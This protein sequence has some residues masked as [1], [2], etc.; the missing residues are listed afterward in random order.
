MTRRADKRKTRGAL[1]NPDS[2][3]ATHTSA[4]F[5]DGWGTL[6]A[7]DDPPPA[8]HVHNDPARR[9]ISRNSSPDVGFDYS[10]NPYKGCS[11]GCVYCFARP[12]HE[13]LDHSA[14]LDFETEIYAKHDAAAR[15]EAEL[16]APGYICRPITL[17][18]NTDPYQPDEHALEITRDLLDVA[19]RFNQPVSIVT[20]SG[21]VLRDLDYLTSLA[22]R[23][24]VNVFI[25]LTSLD[26]E[27]KRSLEPRAAAPARRLTTIQT[28]ANAGVPVGV[29]VAPVIPA[30]TDAE[31]E[32]L[33]ARAAE[34]GAECA[35]YVM[36]RLPHGVKH[37]FREWLATAYPN[38]VDHVMSLVNQLHGGRDY[39]PSW[40]TRMTGTGE[41]ARLFETRFELAC[42]RH[43]LSHRTAFDLD[44]HHF[45]P[46]PTAGDQYTFDFDG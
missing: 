36:L 16:R 9:V 26:R 11:H 33:I 41:F 32:T 34:A 20:K 46:P 2:R 25:S 45:S 23:G 27:L 12:T 38:R 28:L 3:F 37:L 8:T 22:N 42:R 15:L 18:A 5:D 17:G 31:L 6:E 21:L 10:I 44:C 35:G 30:L 4:T 1:S 40:G 14:G 29:L 13:Y 39:D 7:D 43:K 24:L 19:D